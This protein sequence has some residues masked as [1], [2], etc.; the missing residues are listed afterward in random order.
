MSDIEQA[1]KRAEQFK[2]KLEAEQTFKSNMAFLKEH[3]PGLYEYYENYQPEDMFLSFDEDGHFNLQNKNG[4]F[5]YPGDP[6]LFSSQQLEEFK[7]KPNAKYAT[8][9][10]SEIDDTDY[11]H[12]R[13]L[14]ELFTFYDEPN[15]AQAHIRL[16]YTLPE[17]VQTVVILGIGLGYHIK[18]LLDEKQ[19][20][21]LCIYEPHP[22]SFYCSLHVVNWAEIISKYLE[23]GYNIEFCIGKPVHESYLFLNSFF[24]RIGVFNLI[25]SY[26][27]KHYDSK[28]VSEL[29][30]LLD[31]DLLKIGLGIG[32]YDD[33][34]V[35]IAHTIDNVRSQIPIAKKSLS[36]RGDISKRTA[37]V[38][39]NGP[40]L[41][42]NEEF[43]QR[44]K[45]DVYIISSGTALAA[46]EKK[47]I[48]PDIHVEQERNLNQYDWISNSTS[49][50]FRKGVKLCA[51]NTVHPKVF[52]LFDESYIVAKPNDMGTT[53]LMHLLVRDASNSMVLA[54]FC[55]PTVTNFAAS[56]CVTLGFKNIVMVGVDLGM[57]SPEEHHSKDS[58]YYEGESDWNEMIQKTGLYKSKGNFRD[59]VW[60]NSIL[61]K[62]RVS[63]QQLIA[64]YGLKCINVND[65]LKIEGAYA[66]RSDEL[67]IEGEHPLSINDELDARFSSVFSLDGFNTLTNDYVE[68]QL[69]SISTAMQAYRT[70]INVTVNEIDDVYMVCRNVHYF[71]AKNK[72]LGFIA[73]GLLKGTL[74]Y[75]SSVMI[76]VLTVA[77]KE[78]VADM[79]ARIIT[80]VDPF[81]SEIVEDALSNIYQ[82]DDYTTYQ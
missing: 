37:I 56:L 22:E 18:G 82:L 54:D 45:D 44:V 35:G 51:L 47:G 17:K 41:D 34:R 2:L 48:K 14:R 7:N 29:Y 43:L 64:K 42:L 46:L 78:D 28:E 72:D 11:I 26:L 80:V 30:R 15:K 49:S 1:I 8:F 52:E 23:P 62:S 75:I 53:L 39:G 67:S 5:V 36:S 31:Q 73:K 32:F 13:L 61:D 10:D 25:C 81:L 24:G 69:R 76:S 65:G 71:F 50:E 58:A 60:T 57:V 20:R 3:L 74:E 38:I 4:T 6:E 27:Y 59:E 33:E 63:F 55:N 77:K 12:Q 9:I 16:K 79:Y 40:S 21:N 66:F 19:V 70:M 68:S